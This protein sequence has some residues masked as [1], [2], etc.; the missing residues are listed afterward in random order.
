MTLEEVCAFRLSN[1][2]KV[3][4]LHPMAPS[5]SWYGLIGRSAPRWWPLTTAVCIQSKYYRLVSPHLVPN[6]PAFI[7]NNIVAIIPNNSC[8]VLEGQ[9][10]RSPIMTRVSEKPNEIN[11]VTQHP[12]SSEM[13]AVLF[14]LLGKSSNF[15]GLPCWEY[16]KYPF[17]KI[18]SQG[19]M[20]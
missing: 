4:N 17:R 15:C 7:R 18:V 19:A 9:E 6:D 12:F 20:E 3:Y 2:C 10:W 8:D 5:G 13:V 16:K 11:C 1:N 14:W